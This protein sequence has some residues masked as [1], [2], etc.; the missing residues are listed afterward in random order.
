M[1][2]KIILLILHLDPLVYALISLLLQMVSTAIVSKK[3]SF[4]LILTEYHF[5]VGTICGLISTVDF[6]AYAIFSIPYCFLGEGIAVTCFL[7]SIIGIYPMV[8]IFELKYSSI[9]KDKTAE[10]TEE[11]RLAIFLLVR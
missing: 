8:S 11:E 2:I 9:L 4:Q 3:N 6:L 5:F 7:L 10:K 1:G